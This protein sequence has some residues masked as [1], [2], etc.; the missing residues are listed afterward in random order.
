MVADKKQIVVCGNYGA[1]NLG[2]EAILG[3]L[4]NLIKSTWPHSEITVM[5]ARPRQTSRYFQVSS[6]MPFPAGLRSFFASG[7]QLRVGVHF[8]ESAKPILLFW[9]AADFLQMSGLALSGSGLHNGC[10]SDYSAKKSFVWPRALAHWKTK[11]PDGW[12]PGF[13]GLH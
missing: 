4:I 11:L 7:L 5:S 3:G 6:I 8:E 13:S 2:D 1:S 12:R 10:G 9:E